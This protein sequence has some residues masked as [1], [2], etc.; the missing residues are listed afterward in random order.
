M[1]REELVKN[2]HAWDVIKTEELP[3]NF[4]LLQI[5]AL[6]TNRRNIDGKSY[7]SLARNQHIPQYCGSCWA[8]AATSSITDRLKYMTK[9]AWPEHDLSI[10]VILY[11][12]EIDNGC[13]GVRLILSL[14]RRVYLSIFISTLMRSVF[15]KR[16][17]NVT[18]LAT[19]RHAMTFTFVETATPGMAAGQFTT[20]QSTMWRSTDMWR[21]WRIL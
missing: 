21:V 2:P 3:K 4:D 9:N 15:P 13:H 18:R 16:A 19:M 5:L 10:Q 11:C 7:V 6:V 1:V 17:V 20:T 12:S 8:H 14:H